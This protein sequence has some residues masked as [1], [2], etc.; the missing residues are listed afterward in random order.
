MPKDP[1]QLFPPTGASEALHALLPPPVQ[2]CLRLPTRWPARCPAGS[3]PG[4]PPKAHFGGLPPGG[5][6]ADAPASA[7]DSGLRHP[8][9][10]CVT[11]TAGGSARAG[12]RPAGDQAGPWP[13]GEAV[14]RHSWLGPRADGHPRSPGGRRPPRHCSLAPRGFLRGAHDTLDSSPR[15][16]RSFAALRRPHA[17]PRRP[18]A[19]PRTPH[20]LPRTAHACA[21]LARARAREARRSELAPGARPSAPPGLGSAARLAPGIQAAA[22]APGGPGSASPQ[23]RRAAAAAR[24]RVASSVPGGHQGARGG[25]GCSA[26]VLVSLL[27][28]LLARLAGRLIGFFLL[29]CDLRAGHGGGQ[30]RP[31]ARVGKAPSLAQGCRAGLPG[32]EAPVGGGRRPFSTSRCAGGIHG[33]P[34]QGG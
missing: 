12:G 6:S 22:A 30:R 26:S 16:A 27:L 29:P 1:R 10:Y 9:L 8:V 2:A 23:L 7:Q 17:A 31:A 21:V 13:L 11:S 4:P 20:A 33:A 34:A 32:G 14:A 15:L 5:V 18:H 25:G 3:V 24:G 28:V 19:A